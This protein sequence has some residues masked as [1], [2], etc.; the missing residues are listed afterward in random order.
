MTMSSDMLNLVR[1]IAVTSHGIG[2][3]RFSAA[4]RRARCSGK[5]QHDVAKLIAGPSEYICDECVG[6]AG[7]LF[8]R[9]GRQPGA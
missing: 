9:Y 8:M 5:H 7:A 2:R 6:D 3:R 1:R 4:W